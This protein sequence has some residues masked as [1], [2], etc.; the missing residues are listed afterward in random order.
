MAYH[1]LAVVQLKMQHSDLALKSVQ[2]AR[3]IARLCLSA[4]TRYLATFQLTFDAAQTDM[5]FHVK[6]RPG[7]AGYGDALEGAND[8]TLLAVNRLADDYFKT[9]P[10][11]DSEGWSAIHAPASSGGE[12][13]LKLPTINA[14]R[15]QGGGR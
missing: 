2:N 14:S 12:G 11:I 9:V 3:K 1:N 8:S 13:G 7:P 6:Y 15:G 4:S 10:D 5:G